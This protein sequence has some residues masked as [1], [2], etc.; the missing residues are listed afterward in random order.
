MKR[1]IFLGI[2]GICLLLTTSYG[3][4]IGGNKNISESGIHKIKHIIII[5]QE[6]RSFDSYFGTF[7]GAYGIPMKDGFPAVSVWDPYTKKYVMPY[8]DHYDSNRGGPHGYTAF[9]ADV[10]HGKMDGFIKEAHQPDVMG[11]HTESDIPNYW[12][13]AKNFVLQDHMFESIHSWSFPSHLFLVSLWSANSKTPNNPMSFTSTDNPRNRNKKNPEPFGWTDLTYLLHKNHVSWRCYLDGKVPVI[14]N[15]LPGFVDIHQDFQIHNIVG[16]KNYFIAAKKGTLPSV[17]WIFPDWKDSE[18]PPALVSTGQSYVTRIINAAMKSPD[19][20]ST[21]IFLTWDDWGGFYDNVVPPEVDKLGYGIRVPGLVISP[22]AK[23]GY[24]DH[25]ILS[26]D[27]YAKFIEDD[28][29]HGERLNP[30]TDGRPDSR[31]DVR[32]DMPLLGNFIKDFNFAQ[33]PWS[34][35]ILPVH[36]K[37]TLIKGPMHYGRVKNGK[38]IEMIKKLGKEIE[39]L[40]REIKKLEKLIISQAKQ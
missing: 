37:T 21:A 35:L 12:A 5:F 28:F 2:S 20:K 15:I 19:W 1:L 23:K 36:P 18:H 33:K 38:T 27:A 17:C 32:E 31:P 7:P 13:Y 40:K 30:K 9:L 25:Q 26:F 16:I 8:V 22:Y 24:I 39:G 34:P 11:Y 3:Q 10:D 6:N 14:W 29:C 4:M